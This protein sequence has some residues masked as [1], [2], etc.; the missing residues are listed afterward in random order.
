[1]AKKAQ[2][3][4]GSKQVSSGKLGGDS[5]KEPSPLM[6]LAGGAKGAKKDYAKKPKSPSTEIGSSSFGMT[7]LTGET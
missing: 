4:S 5:S 2:L 6:S 3:S 1:M 7:G